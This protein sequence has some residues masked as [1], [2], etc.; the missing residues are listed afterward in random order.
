MRYRPYLHETCA[1]ESWR[2]SREPTPREIAIFDRAQLGASMLEQLPI[3]HH[4]RWMERGNDDDVSWIAPPPWQRAKGADHAEP[5]EKLLGELEYSSTDYFG[6]E[7][8][9]AAFYMSA[10]LLATVPP[11]TERKRT[12]NREPR[13]NTAQEPRGRDPLTIA[14]RHRGAD[15]CVRA[16]EM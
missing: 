6:N 3:E 15:P 7:G 12:A 1:G 10:A 14:N 2:L 9:D 5:A 11:A 4:A 13:R 8:S 16:D